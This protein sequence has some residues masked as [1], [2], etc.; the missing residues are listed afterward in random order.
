MDIA[1]LCSFE[2]HQLWHE[3]LRETLLSEPPPGHR[4]VSY[5]QL[6]NADRALFVFVAKRC[7]A[8]AGVQPPGTKTRFELAWTEGMFADEVRYLLI[9]LPSGAGPSAPSGA[10]SP[11][12]NVQSEPS[13]AKELK[14]VQNQL[15]QVQEQ[16]QAAKRKA[17]TQGGRSSTSG[18]GKARYK[19]GK[20]RGNSGFNAMEVMKSHGLLTKHAL[21]GT[22]FCFAFN[23][24]EGCTHAS[25]GQSCP[26]GAHIC[27]RPSCQD[28]KHPHSAQSSH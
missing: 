3:K 25:P 4:P 16:L 27:A 20:Q 14:K 26:R 28:R 12:G 18:G 23:L 8:G 19:Q 6:E 7:S 5:K 15:K 10:A 11:A 13:T 1:G 21:D 22:R 2:A 24:P 9:P 17:E